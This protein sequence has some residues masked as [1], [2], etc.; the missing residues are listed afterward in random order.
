MFIKFLPSPAVTIFLFAFSLARP[1]LLDHEVLK[2]FV[3][4]VDPYIWYSIWFFVGVSV[5]HLYADLAS[6]NSEIKA[7]L[8]NKYKIFD[9]LSFV[10]SSPA[11]TENTIRPRVKIKFKK[12][13]RSNV[14]LNVMSLYPMC[15]YQN[16][17]TSELEVEKE[18][19]K[20]DELTV[21]LAT[22]Y[23][24]GHKNSEWNCFNNNGDVHSFLKHTQHIVTLIVGN[25]KHR[26]Y[27]KHFR[28]GGHEQGI[29]FLLDEERDIWKAGNHDQE[30]FI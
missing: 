26:F 8:K 3:Q 10:P 4:I 17:F 27:I 18:Y 23:R 29:C 6:K 16:V 24:E 5:G 11:H 9:V 12:N 1:K 25:Q 15:G 21:D 14:R 20:G 22:I 2:G 13:I 28:Q 30:I 7:F 19:K